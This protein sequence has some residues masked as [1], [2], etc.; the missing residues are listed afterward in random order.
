MNNLQQLIKKAEA[1]N[2]KSSFTVTGNPFSNVQITYSEDDLTKNYVKFLTDVF[3]NKY[4]D[5]SINQIEALGD[6]IKTSFNDFKK[7]YQTKKS[8]IKEIVEGVFIHTSMNSH[9]MR[10]K[11]KN[12]VDSLY[13]TVT[14]PKDISDELKHNELLEEDV[15]STDDIIKKMYLFQFEREHLEDELNKKISPLEFKRF[16]HDF[17]SSYFVSFFDC[18]ENS[19]NEWK[20]NK[21][22]YKSED[23]RD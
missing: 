7:S 17:S 23:Y 12:V 18:L 20:R 16:V 14:W 2:K 19:M 13:G 8:V 22:K 11:I 9:T 1:R 6:S 5:V 3:E 15:I 21:E 10:I 4:G